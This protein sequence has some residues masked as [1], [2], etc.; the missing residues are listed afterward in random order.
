MSL[1]ERFRRSRLTQQFVTLLGGRF[2]AAGI[3]AVS[4]YLLA[5]W[6]RLDEFGVMA[7][8]LGVSVTLQA[9]G[10]A[11]ATTYIVRETAA[12]GI[13]Y[14][15]AYAEQLSRLVMASVVAGWLF[16]VLALTAVSGERYLSLL[17][18]A[19]WIALDRGSDIRSAIARGLGDVR[20]GTI[21]LVSRRLVQ[22]L[23]F[24]L[25]FHSGIGA[26]W[27]YSI[28]LLLGSALVLAWMWRKLPRPAALPF[29][30]KR[31]LYAFMR[32]KPYWIHSAATQLRNLDAALV[33]MIS[34]P[35]QAAYYGVGAR[36]MTPLR[37]VPATLA[38]ALL[39]H[40]VR[41][42]GVGRKD[43][44][45]GLYAAL[46]IGLPYLALAVAA[47]WA[48]R[49]LGDGF[50]GASL[51]LQLMCVG[52][53][54]SAF[55]SIFNAILQS[56]KRAS[57]VARI[58]TGTMLALLALVAIG[59]ELCGAAGAATG[60]MLATIAQAAFVFYGARKGA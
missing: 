43:I 42:G 14:S 49:H 36:L 59:T 4:I 38:T 19:G 2:A 13:N 17:P 6:A 27:A 31:L 44:S 52:L 32:C 45:L 1:I 28:S 33:A 50:E 39:P 3:Q 48:V 24:V 34:G 10:D 26:S 47:P 7:S 41:S 55:I 25:F 11:G 60:F 30:K 20:L 21:N 9:I 12:H 37:M 29:R 40:L 46:V 35:V 16:V 57:L 58:S 56:R 5:R 53:A 8:A 18:L 54:G 51:P 23:L 15:V 22:L